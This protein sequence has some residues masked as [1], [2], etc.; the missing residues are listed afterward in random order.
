MVISDSVQEETAFLHLGR[1]LWAILGGSSYAYLLFENG[2]ILTTITSTTSI[3]KGKAIAT[4]NANKYLRY[5]YI[6]YMSRGRY[7]YFQKGYRAHDGVKLRQN[8]IY[9]KLVHTTGVL[10]T[11]GPHING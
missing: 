5:C 3:H 6:C 11:S 4:I 8:S 7:T 9:N 10:A 1:A 2:T